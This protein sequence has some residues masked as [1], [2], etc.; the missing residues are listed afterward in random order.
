MKQQS[1]KALTIVII[2]LLFIEFNFKDNYKFN[3]SY[4]EDTTLH[5]K[6][7]TTELEAKSKLRLNRTI[8]IIDTMP[9]FFKEYKLNIKSKVCKE[10][11]QKDSML[12]YKRAKIIHDILLNKFNEYAKRLTIHPT[13][14]LIKKEDY[15]EK[16]DYCKIAT[17]VVIVMQYNCSSK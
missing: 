5:F 6:Y 8:S 3:L 4:T 14:L 9:N 2:S 10:E 17:G 16:A 13:P 7:M 12:F 1:L 15:F 11:H